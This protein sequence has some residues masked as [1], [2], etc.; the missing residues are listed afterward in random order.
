MYNFNIHTPK[1]NYQFITYS[2]TY[3]YCSLLP[4]CVYG[5]TDHERYQELKELSKGDADFKILL[6]HHP[7]GFIYPYSPENKSE[8]FRTIFN[9]NKI[10]LVLS[11][12]V[13]AVLGK[14]LYTYREEYPNWDLTVSDWKMNSMY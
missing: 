6:S 11:G 14:Q 8:D 10:D 12:H 7:Y 13:H 5:S 1:Y 4:F 3:P 9:E 2:S